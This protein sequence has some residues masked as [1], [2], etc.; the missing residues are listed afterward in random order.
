[1]A[2]TDSPVQVQLLFIVIISSRYFVLLVCVRLDALQATKPKFSMKEDSIILRI[3]LIIACICMHASFI[4]S[5]INPNPYPRT[6]IPAF[7]LSLLTIRQISNW[8]IHIPYSWCSFNL[9]TTILQPSYIG[10]RG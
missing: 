10:D 9:I 5:S 4:L 6:S 2:Q 7:T 8:N 3:Y 1:M